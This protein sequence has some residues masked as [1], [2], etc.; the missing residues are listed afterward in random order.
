MYTN[1]L[2]DVRHWIDA[3]EKGVLVRNMAELKQS[4]EEQRFSRVWKHG[5]GEELAQ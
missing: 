3:T 1:L 5:E 4:H 2:G